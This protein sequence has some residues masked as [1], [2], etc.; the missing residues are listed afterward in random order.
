MVTGYAPKD[1]APWEAVKSVRG[2]TTARTVKDDCRNELD[3]TLAQSCK[4]EE[5][6]GGEFD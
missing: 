2:F 6:G 5:L 4:E 3:G 1:K